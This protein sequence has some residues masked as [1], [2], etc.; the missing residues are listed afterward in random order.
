MTVL[1]TGVWSIIGLRVPYC[2]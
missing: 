1:Q 2:R